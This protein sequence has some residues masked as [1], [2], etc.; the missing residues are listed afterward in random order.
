[1]SNPTDALAFFL[2][3]RGHL[4]M[5]LRDLS[6]N[7]ECSCGYDAARAEAKRLREKAALCD[8]IMAAFRGGGG[9]PLR[10]YDAIWL[11]RYSAIT[12]RKEEG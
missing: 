11:N 1:M 5:C 10:P 4:A 9:Y 12:E 7:D 2:E 6:E 3:K 8:E